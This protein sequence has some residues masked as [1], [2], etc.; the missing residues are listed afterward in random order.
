MHVQL[1]NHAQIA[2][3][4]VHP[5]V[6]L[7]DIPE[8]LDKAH[9][10]QNIVFMPVRHEMQNGPQ[11]Q[12]HDIRIEISQIRRMLTTI[13]VA[14]NRRSGADLDRPQINV[15]QGWSVAEKDVEGSLEKP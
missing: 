5:P 1:R 13:A 7:I 3:K 2:Q 11:L 6:L 8:I 9:Y 10:A 12:D 15:P 14:N 4:L